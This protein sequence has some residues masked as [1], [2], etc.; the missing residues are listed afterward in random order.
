MGTESSP[1]TFNSSS[2]PPDLADPSPNYPKP[3]LV[4]TQDVN[5]LNFCS[6]GLSQSGTFA[7]P[8]TIASERIDVYTLDASFGVSRLFKALDASDSL[9][10]DTQIQA[11]AEKTSRRGLL[12][13]VMVLK[14]ANGTLLAG[15]ESGHVAKFDLSTGKVHF[16]AE[17]HKA[18]IL[19]IVVESTV[20]YV[21]AA[22][23]NI[24]LLDLN[25]GQCKVATQLLHRGVASVDVLPLL[26]ASLLVTAG[27]DGE[28]RIFSHSRKEGKDSIVEE[29]SFPGGRQDGISLATV[30]KIQHVMAKRRLKRLPPAW[31]IV[32]GKDGRIGLH[33]YDYT[34]NAPDLINTKFQNFNIEF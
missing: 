4:Y 20:A 5:A 14:I 23:K 16:V 32:A 9:P 27:W 10:L 28:V 21:S 12:G 1:Q 34:I 24:S 19:S 22:N 17:T 33:A 26:N 15:Y 11:E 3:W 30:H 29:D 13:A 8:A 7:A 2:L 31:I 25:T 18:P 6:I